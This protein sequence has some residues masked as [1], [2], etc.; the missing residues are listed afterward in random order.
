[1]SSSSLGAKN[2]EL[3]PLSLRDNASSAWEQPCSPVLEIEFRIG[4]NMHG[5]YHKDLTQDVFDKLVGRLHEATSSPD[6]TEDEYVQFRD[7]VFMIGS[8]RVRSRTNFDAKTCSVSVEL[9]NKTKIWSRQSTV[10]NPDLLCLT[11][12]STEVPVDPADSVPAA[13]IVMTSI[14]Y[15]K[16]FHLLYPKQSAKLRVDCTK[17]WSDK[18]LARCEVI[19]ASEPPSHTV[20][21]EVVERGTLSADTVAETI[22]RLSCISV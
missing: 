21:V 17:R 10:R 7:V 4:S 16:S 22:D 8:R 19:C 11:C 5:S 18:T 14:S 6:V 13:D 3:N 2:M 12:V 1:M 15:R 9:V 20:E